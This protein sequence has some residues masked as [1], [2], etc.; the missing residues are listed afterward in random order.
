M[1]RRNKRTRKP[2][3]GSG[4]GRDELEKIYG[5]IHRNVPTPYLQNMW[6]RDVAKMQADPGFA[7]RF[8][9]KGH[10]KPVEKRRYIRG[11]R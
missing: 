6:D 1:P 8:G 10:R 4:L 11:K 7:S 5:P 9:R 2:T 3:G